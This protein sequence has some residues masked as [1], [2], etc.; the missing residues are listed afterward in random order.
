MTLPAEDVFTLRNVVA[1]QIPSFSSH[2]QELVHAKITKNGQWRVAY[3]SWTRLHPQLRLPE[4]TQ[5][6]HGRT[7]RVRLVLPRAEALLLAPALVRAALLELQADVAEILRHMG[8]PD[9]ASD[10]GT[11]ED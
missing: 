2:F 1:S 11:D 9:G 5:Q 4:V 7:R 8:P 10:F 3:D 6:T